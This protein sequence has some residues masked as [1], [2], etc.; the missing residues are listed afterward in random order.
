MPASGS[1]V[2]PVLAPCSCARHCSFSVPV[3]SAHRLFASALGIP[4]VSPGRIDPPLI[5][6]SAGRLPS[7]EL[8]LSGEGAPLVCA[9]LE[10][11]K[12]RATTSARDKDESVMTPSQQLPGLYSRDDPPTRTRLVRRALPDGRLRAPLHGQRP[13]AH[14]HG[15][16]PVGPGTS[17]HRARPFR[18]H[19][20][21]RVFPRAD[22]ARPLGHRR[23]AGGKPRRSSAAPCRRRSSGRGGRR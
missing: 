10:L 20:R 3:R 15:G 11:A 23:L 12:V 2:P 18:L 14:L 9:K 5:A 1:R 4:A 7:A 6:P 17:H 16:I 19:R 13:A 21:V 22:L 8:P